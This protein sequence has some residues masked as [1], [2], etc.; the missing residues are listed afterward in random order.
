MMILDLHDLEVQVPG[1][2]QGKHVLDEE[3]DRQTKNS[4]KI[5]HDEW[6]QRRVPEPDTGHQA[7]EPGPGGGAMM[8]VR[9]IHWEE[10]DGLAGRG[11]TRFP[12]WAAAPVTQPA[13]DGRR[14]M[15]VDWM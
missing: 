8:R 11:Q 12:S 10:L 7:P 2:T 5:P 4:P 13:K 14:R 1:V 15:D 6:N 9:W 3:A